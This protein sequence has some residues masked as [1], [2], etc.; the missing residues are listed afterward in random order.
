[1]RKADAE[2]VFIQKQ[3]FRIQTLIKKV[4]ELRSQLRIAAEIS[5]KSSV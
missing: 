4:Q 5:F 2:T 1:M 3:Q